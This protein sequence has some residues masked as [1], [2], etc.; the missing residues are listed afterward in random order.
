MIAIK[1]ENPRLRV[2]EYGA[3]RVGETN[4]LFDL[5]VSFHLRGESPEDIVDAFSALELADVYWAIGYYL[6][7]REEVDAYLEE[8]QKIAEM[9]ER[10]V[11]ADPRSQAFHRKLDEWRRKERERDAAARR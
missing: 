4:V 11:R 8:G 1:H 6:R 9:W 3:I 2:D 10:R 7:H 5:V